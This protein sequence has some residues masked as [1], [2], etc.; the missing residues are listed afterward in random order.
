MPVLA[1][2]RVVPIRHVALT[3]RIPAVL[4]RKMNR[5]DAFRL[6][7][8][9]HQSGNLPAAEAAYRQ[10]LAIRP[11]ET[12]ALG[13][14]AEIVYRTGRNAE[15]LDLISAAARSFPHDPAVL[16]THGIILTHEAG[17]E[18]AVRVFQQAIAFHPNL[19]EA[20]ARIATPLLAIGRADEAIT[21]CR[22]SLALRPDQP[23][24]IVSLCNALAPSG[25]WTK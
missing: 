24:T 17:F 2:A 1:V 19:A 10:A 25:I 11:D 3:G 21:A 23:P 5:Q 6:A 14:L 15:A 12:A 20:H 9:L 16:L 8:S 7:R 18:E 22:R 4:S 13:A